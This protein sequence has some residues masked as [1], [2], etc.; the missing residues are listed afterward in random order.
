MSDEDTITIEIKGQP[1]ELVRGATYE[2]GFQFPRR[3]T[4]AARFLDLKGYDLLLE[5]LDGKS[6]ARS[7]RDLENIWD[8]SLR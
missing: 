7:V 2:F 4:I 5:T 6:L 1:I 3:V 8:V